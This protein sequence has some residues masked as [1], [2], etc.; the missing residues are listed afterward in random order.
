MPL[1]VRQQRL[2][3]QFAPPIVGSLL[4]ALG[5]I[6]TSILDIPGAANVQIRPA[7]AIPIVCGAFFGPVTGFVSGFVGNLAADQVLGWGWW[8]FWYL[9]SGIMGLVP[10]LLRPTNA[11]YTQLSAIGA[12]L[13]RAVIGI[14]VGMAVAALSEHWVTQSSWN[15][16]LWGNFLPAFL[17]NLVNAVILVPIMLLL[18]GFFHASAK[19]RTA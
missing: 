14:T 12:V 13:L 11:N 17:S 2:L 1:S 6:L 4:Y 8:P 9:G 18:Y 3:F 5:I 15:D 19:Q 16:V 7:V 10:G